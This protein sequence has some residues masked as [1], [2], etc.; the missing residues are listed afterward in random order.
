[1]KSINFPKMLNS[2]TTNIVSNSLEATKRNLKNLLL[3]EKGEFLGDPYFG[4][5]LKRYLFDQNDVILQDIIIDEIY[6]QI[7]TFMPQLQVNRNDIQLD[8]ARGSL[9]V[10]IKATNLVNYTTN[11]YN[12]VLFEEEEQ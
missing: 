1:M 4:V 10:N 3:S 6:T 7:A 12:I 9:F 5:S 8:K 2:N 11:L